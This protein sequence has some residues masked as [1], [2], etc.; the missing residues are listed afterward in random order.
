MMNAP[1][2]Y[3][4]PDTVEGF[5]YVVLAEQFRGSLADPLGNLGTKAD[6]ILRLMTGWIGQPLIALGAVGLGTSL[7]RRPR[8]VILS[9][10]SL[11][12]TCIFA[13]SYANAD[14]SRYYLVPL[15]IV[16]TWAALGA[17]DLIGAAGWLVEAGRAWA[18]DGRVPRLSDVLAAEP[19]P[20]AEP[21]ADDAPGRDSGTAPLRRTTPGWAPRIV[22]AGEVIVAAALVFPAVNIVPLRQQPQ[23]ST[24]PNGVSEANQTSDA[25]W[26]AVVLAP[27]DKGGLPKNSVI[28][29]W[30]STSTTLWYGQKVL[31]MRPDIYIVDDRTRLDDNL[32]EVQDVFNR[33]LGNRPVFTIRL[34]GGVDGMEA[35]STEFDIQTFTLG[36]GVTT[37]AH[38]IGRKESQ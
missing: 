38:V 11:V 2:I 36:D 8:Y 26:L 25:R 18:F 12:A 33:F 23:S 1:V 4:H 32:G 24:N 3:G 13:A 28:V 37:I 17:A 22:L 19:S 21:V 14:I 6:T 15:M 29:S 20:D 34:S 27:A 5:K 31:G 16:L 35:L 10:L 9:G 7:A 30:W